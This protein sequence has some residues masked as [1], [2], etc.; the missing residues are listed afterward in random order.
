MSLTPMGKGMR[1]CVRTEPTDFNV[2]RDLT[3]YNTLLIVLFS[4]NDADLPTVDD[5][6]QHH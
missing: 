6:W 2:V 1:A 3:Y 4:G 5:F